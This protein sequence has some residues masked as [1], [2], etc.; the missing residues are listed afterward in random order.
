MLYNLNVMAFLLA[1]GLSGPVS[2]DGVRLCSTASPETTGYTVSYCSTF[3]DGYVQLFSFHPARCAV[4]FAVPVFSGANAVQINAVETGLYLN[5]TAPGFTDEF[6]LYSDG[7]D[8]TS[9]DSLIAT[10]QYTMSGTMDPG[11]WLI[12]IDD[13]EAQGLV[14]P[15][16]GDSAV[17][18]FVQDNIVSG[19]DTVLRLVDTSVADNYTTGYNFVD[20][21]STGW[22]DLFNWGWGNDFVVK[23]W[24]T[25][26]TVGVS[27]TGPRTEAGLSLRPNPARDDLVIGFSLLDDGPARITLFD[28]TG[29]A[30][31]DLYGGPGRR[32]D[33]LIRVELG[34][35]RPGVYTVVLEA[36]RATRTQRLILR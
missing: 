1:F 17:F 3:E 26:T 25:P 9:P 32:G 16:D 19:E 15:A 8:H 23:L 34:D 5:Y 20:Y 30:V 29:R 31:R 12:L 18:W 36:G 10:L 14:V 33:N 6:S 13:L 35:L 28:A 27:E 11:I 4:R 2:A 24:Y 21:D 7:A 22:V